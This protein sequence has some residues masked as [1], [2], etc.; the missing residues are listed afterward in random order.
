MNILIT[1][2]ASGIARRVIEKLDAKQHHIYV[3]VH[4]TKQLE[5]VQLRYHNQKHIT[6]LKLDITDEKDRKQIASL[7][8]DI[9]VSNAAIGY[10]GSIAEIPIDLVRDNFDVNVFSNFSLVQLALKGMIQRKHGRVIMMSSL[11]GVAPVPFLGS[12]CA[13]KASINMLT[14]KLLLEMKLLRS[15]E[16]ASELQSQHTIS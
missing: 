3:A 2:A 14:S 13:S 9:L 10:S 1:G 8:I 5:L 11:A 7:P 12:Y 15:E 6:C 4:T 16:H